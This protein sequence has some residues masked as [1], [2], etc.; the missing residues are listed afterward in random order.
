M[1]GGFLWQREAE[2]AP[3]ADYTHC[4]DLAAVGL[5][6]TFGDAEAQTG[7]SRGPR[8]GRI[9]PVGTL[10]QAPQVLLRYSSARVG[11]LDLNL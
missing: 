6:D 7:A 8:P 9:D 1:A 11:D 2:G 3:L 5:H 10:K 4:P